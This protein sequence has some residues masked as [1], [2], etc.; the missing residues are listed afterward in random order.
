MKKSMNYGML[1]PVFL[2]L[3]AAAML[4]RRWLFTRVE[5]SIAYLL[6]RLTL[7]EV[8]LWVL[9]AAAIV[10]AFILTRKT[11]LT[12]PAAGIAVA[13]DVLL[14]GGIL[15]LF[16]ED[17]PGPSALVLTYRVF[18]VLAVL[19][20]LASALLTGIHKKVPFLLHLSPCILLV[21][22]LLIC[23]QLWSEV[24][25]LM[26]YVLGLGAVLCLALAG[27]FRLARAAGLPEKCW[28]HA[29]G[30]L[31]IYFCAGAAG[32]GTFGFFFT[33]AAI[34]L[35]CTYAGLRPAEA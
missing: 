8:I 32:Q 22:H 28:Y 9:T 21:L 6:P 20:L 5:D 11:A 25:Q 12:V 26:N 13:G 24:P 14:A 1:A 3:G 4:V 10:S 7:P 17:V 34:W 2:V 23:Y 31:G 27:Y 19:S 18:C 35:A 16:F 30:L 15:L 33:A 29:I